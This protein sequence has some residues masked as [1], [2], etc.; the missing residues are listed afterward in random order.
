PVSAVETLLAAGAAPVA[1]RARAARVLGALDDERA[2]AALL[3]AVGSGTPELRLAAVRA[4][5]TS[6]SLA[7][8][9]LFAQLSGALG[10]APG[11]RHLAAR[12]PG[13][14][15]GAPAVAALRGALR[16]GDPRVRE[17]AAQGLGQNHDAGATAALVAGAKQEPWPFVRRAELEALGSIC[18]PGGG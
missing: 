4:L 9:A 1:D 7:P 3:A 17:T 16:D 13:A 2:T 15:G 14:R 5:G 10:G 8:E 18:P 6:P 12:E 11:G